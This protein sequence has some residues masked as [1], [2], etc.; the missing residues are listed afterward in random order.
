MRPV[1]STSVVAVGYDKAAHALYVEFVDGD[2]YVYSLVPRS[3]FEGLMQA[4]SKGSFVNRVVKP[5]YPYR[6]M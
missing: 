5:R 4:S 3:T 6:R 2:T 1:S